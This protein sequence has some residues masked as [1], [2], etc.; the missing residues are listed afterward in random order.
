MSYRR[1]R[2]KRGLPSQ[3]NGRTTT[4]QQDDRTAGRAPG[5]FGERGPVT[6]RKRPD[7]RD[8]RNQRDPAP[9]LEPVPRVPAPDPPSPRDHLA[10]VRVASE[11]LDDEPRPA[12][13]TDVHRLTVRRR[14]GRSAAASTRQPPPRS[15]E[16]AR[17][18]TVRR[19]DFPSPFRPRLSA[20]RSD[21]CGI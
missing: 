3:K 9:G 15:E 21:A 13:S 14:F 18:P 12:T 6:I 16:R 1:D 5:T 10:S 19:R 7:N 4:G 2:R 11:E 8:E 20:A 17:S